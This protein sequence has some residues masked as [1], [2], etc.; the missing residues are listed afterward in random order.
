[1]NLNIVVVALV[2]A[3]FAPAI[4]ALFIVGEP[5]LSATS[6]LAA[7]L[8]CITLI[9]YDHSEQKVLDRRMRRVAAPLSGEA[10]IDDDSNVEISV[11]RQRRAKSWLPD[12]LDQ[13]FS[14]IDARQT[15]PKAVGLGALGALAVGLG[16]LGALV[17]GLGAVFADFGWLSVLLLP[18]GGLGE[19]WAVLAR[20]DAKQRA[21]F[22]EFFPES[23]D[24]VVRLMRSGLPSVEAISV[25]AEEA[26]P[27]INGVMRDISEAVSA[28]LDP[29]TVIRKTAARVRIPEFTLF[30]AAVCLQMT[31][32]GGISSA[33]GNLS[34]T[35][36]SRYESGLKAK[37]ATAQ[38]RL[39]LIVI[40][41]V[42]IVVLG[43]QTFTNPQVTQTLFFTESGT[44]L[45]RYGIGFIV[46][47][48]LIARGLAA[49][50]MR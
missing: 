15:L 28:G 19:S 48:V 37:S 3:V 7:M 35:L 27:P 9:L 14:M 42:P 5:L 47:G 32:G 1:M 20:Q 12:Y 36:R 41:V 33:L 44:S 25:V 49:R 18:A 31:T 22:L 24:H 21:K 34:A 17:A 38:T 29:E 8:L 43:M 2:A 6:A 4:L 50:A 10:V 46:V 13:Q 26:P 30:S 39:T 23:V 40:S 11:I 16:A 45:L